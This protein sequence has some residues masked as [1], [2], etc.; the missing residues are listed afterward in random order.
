VFSIRRRRLRTLLTT[1]AVAVSLTAV[2]CGSTGEPDSLRIYAIGAFTG[3][4]AAQNV[5][6]RDGAH[7][8]VTVLN[9][10]GGVDGKRLELVVKDDRGDLAATVAAAREAAGDSSAYG[11]VLGGGSPAVDAVRAFLANQGRPVF[12]SSTN[13]AFSKDDFPSFYRLNT[14]TTESAESTLEYAQQRGQT[15]LGLIT[16]NNDYGEGVRKGYGDLAPRYGVEVV[17]E[18]T[19]PPTANV[20]TPEIDRLRSSGAQLVVGALNPAQTLAAAQAADTAA[21]EADFWF[22]GADMT[23]PAVRQLLGEHADGL[24]V[25]YVRY[26][27]DPRLQTDPELPA[28]QLQMS[29]EATA[30]WKAWWAEFG[31]YTTI[32]GN[33]V[34]NLPS[35]EWWSYDAVL[36]IAEAARGGTPPEGMVD[37]VDRIGSFSLVGEYPAIGRTHEFRSLADLQIARLRADG[38]VDYALAET[39]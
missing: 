33:E 14:K 29:A 38:T 32:N 13:P 20:L 21:W 7:V 37:A 6:L 9:E 22:N 30:F 5:P 10:R 15:K 8:A 19:V 24:F 26:P 1:T 12:S 11:I 39:P 17:A 23:F 3:P 34:A 36:M 27:F 28:D 16:V 18:V 31:G 2:A 4:A 25:R 35:F